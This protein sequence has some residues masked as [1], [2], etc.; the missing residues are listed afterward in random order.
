MTRRIALFDLDRTLLDCNSGRLWV[1][2]ELRGGR[3]GYRDAA[4]ASWWLLRYHLG[5]GDGL[6]QVFQ[7]A[8]E[9]MAGTPESELEGR[10]IRWFQSEVG[11][12]LRPG[13][14]AALQAHRERGDLLVLATSSSSYVAEAAADRFALD[15]TL[16]TEFEV[17]DGRLTGRVSVLALGRGK[18]AIA[19]SWAAEHG[20]DLKDAVF[21]TDSATDLSL[22][23]RVGEPVAVCPDRAL[24]RIAQRRGWRIEDWGRAG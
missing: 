20:F 15:H 16:A 22:M 9:S 17:A 14:R 11:H 6:E 2:H 12:R 24:A 1:Q 18:A 8:V 23:E 21:Y 5:M 7:A 19:A 4:W 10:T 3:I 13:A